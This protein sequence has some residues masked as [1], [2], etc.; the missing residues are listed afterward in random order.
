[1][2]SLPLPGCSNDSLPYLQNASIILNT[3]LSAF[4]FHQEILSVL[5]SARLKS[6]QYLIV[7][8]CESACA[9]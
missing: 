7:S 4:N 3:N 1:M 6:P 8:S 5:I 9:L 2:E